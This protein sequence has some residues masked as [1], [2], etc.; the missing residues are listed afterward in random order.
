[1]EESKRSGFK[2][3]LK[4][5]SITRTNSDP[6]APSSRLTNQGLGKKL[7]IPLVM[8]QNKGN[9]SHSIVETKD[10]IDGVKYRNTKVM[11]PTRPLSVCIPGIDPKTRWRAHTVDLRYPLLG[12][13][14]PE[15]SAKSIVDKRDV[16]SNIAE[17]DRPGTKNIPLEVK[18]YIN[19]LD[20]HSDIVKRRNEEQYVGPEV[21]SNLKSPDIRLSAEKE[22]ENLKESFSIKDKKSDQSGDLLSLETNREYDATFQDNVSM[23][24]GSKI[25]VNKKDECVSKK[26][27]EINSYSNRNDNPIFYGVIPVCSKEKA[28]TLH[29]KRDAIHNH[30]KEGEITGAIKNANNK[31]ST[32]PSSEKD[33]Q[34]CSTFDS[35]SRSDN[36]QIIS[37]KGQIS[38]SNEKQNSNIG[39]N[40]LMDKTEKESGSILESVLVVGKT[41][42][43]DEIQSS[44]QSGSSTVQEVKTSWKD[45]TLTL[46][47]N[48]QQRS[49]KVK[50]PLS[51]ID[52]FLTSPTPR[53]RR[54]P[55]RRRYFEPKTLVIFTWVYLNRVI[56]RTKFQ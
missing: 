31:S 53:P 7:S 55:S 6:K 26:E 27:T 32:L 36:I 15:D 39:N 42:V 56:N 16:N 4:F 18:G 10:D 2:T 45:M 46:N 37:E 21:K 23:E 19:N 25:S 49:K 51:P 47:L 13:V 43:M 30:S 5:M 52:S 33:S 1:M 3:P 20:I 28:V 40:V 50:E 14:S 12:Q 29:P 8:S 9:N 34:K 54:R 38:L 11:T 35:M 17:K 44:D 24:T 22:V 48:D 41:G